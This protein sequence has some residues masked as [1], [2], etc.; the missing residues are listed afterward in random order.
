MGIDLGTSSVKGMLLDAER[1]IIACAATEYAVEIPAAGYAEQNPEMWWNA[2][3]R[4]LGKLKEKNPPAMG[5]ITAVGLSGQMHGLVI[6][7]EPMYA[8]YS[9]GADGCP[10]AGTAGWRL[11]QGSWWGRFWTIGGMV[12][13]RI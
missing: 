7:V 8:E 6:L 1:G 9:A 11:V 10:G 4:T 12:P 13:R 3:L 2:V 5:S